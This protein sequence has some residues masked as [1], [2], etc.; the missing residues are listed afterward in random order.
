MEIS[1][2]DL[3]D[4]QT[5]EL[6]HFRDQSGTLGS[7]MPTNDQDLAAKP[8]NTNPS[9]SKPAKSQGNLLSFFKKK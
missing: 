9:T 3:P 6:H 1:S 7:A 2:F 8:G 5:H 4:H